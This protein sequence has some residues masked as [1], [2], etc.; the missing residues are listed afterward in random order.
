MLATIAAALALTCTV[1][2][3]HDGDTLSADCGGSRSKVRLAGIDAPELKQSYG[4]ESRQALAD[5]VFQ[6]QVLIKRTKGDRYKRSVA[7][8]SVDGR[9]VSSSMVAGGHAWVYDQYKI[10]ALYP[11]QRESVSLFLFRTWATTTRSPNRQF[12]NQA[13]AR[14]S[15]ALLLRKAHQ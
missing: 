3:V 10:K 9:D 8:V 1:Y 14:L 11:L 2:S 5:L 7:V 6:R 4:R 13:P 12:V 15:Q